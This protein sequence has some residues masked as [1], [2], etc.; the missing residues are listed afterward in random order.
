MSPNL[1][2]IP[3]IISS[4]MFK[5]IFHKIKT[6]LKLSPSKELQKQ[7]EQELDIPDPPNGVEII[8]R[9]KRRRSKQNNK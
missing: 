6:I 9:L 7:I 8:E 2:K 3:Y 4:A 5:Y 1:R